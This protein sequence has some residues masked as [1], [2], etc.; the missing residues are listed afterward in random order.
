MV[1]LITSVFVQLHLEAYF[2]FSLLSG[3]LQ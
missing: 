1:D 2:S 3:L